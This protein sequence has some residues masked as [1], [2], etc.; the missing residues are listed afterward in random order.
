VQIFVVPP[1]SHLYAKGAVFGAR[2]DPAQNAHALG[3]QPLKKT[4]EREIDPHRDV[5]LSTRH[6]K[7]LPAP[8]APPSGRTVPPAAVPARPQPRLRFPWVPGAVI[9]RRGPE[10]GPGEPQ[11]AGAA[12]CRHRQPPR[13][14]R[15]LLG[16]FKSAHEECGASARELT[17][18][19]DGIVR[20]YVRV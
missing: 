19:V 18:P 4:R 7:S 13:R 20:L 14:V 1:G 16:A 11:G 8:A 9:H 3:K 12:V 15:H 2:R 10:P 5:P 17:I 6:G